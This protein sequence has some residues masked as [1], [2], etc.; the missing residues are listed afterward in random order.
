V[1]TENIHA[2]CREDV[3]SCPDPMTCEAFDSVEAARA[4]HAVELREQAAALEA[5]R[6]TELADLADML[7][8]PKPKVDAN[9]AALLREISRFIRRF[10]VFQDDRYAD[11]L[12]LWV[13]HTWAFEA[14][15]STPYIW[16][17]SPEMGSGKTRLLEVLELLVRMPWHVVEPSEPVTFRMI[18]MYMPT[19]LLDEIDVIFSKDRHGD[20]QTGLRG[21]MNAGYRRGA[22]IPRAENFGKDLTNFK[23]YCPK[24]FA[25]IGHAL[26]DTVIDRSIKI[27]LTRKRR[28]ER[29]ERFSQRRVGLEVNAEDGIRHRLAAAAA[30]ADEFLREWREW[31][32]E[33]FLLSSDRHAEVWE[34][35]FAIAEAAGEEW[36]VKARELAHWTSD[37]RAKDPSPGVLLLQ[38]IKEAF[39]DQE[40]IASVVLL[41]TLTFR[42]DAPWGRIWQG[43]PGSQADL[44]GLAARLKEY[45]VVSRT[46]RFENDV[47]LKGY[48]KSD[49]AD[50]WDRYLPS[51]EA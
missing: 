30:A 45:D 11:V 31:V 50:V 19:L 47:K 41:Q 35:L 44:I 39:G 27:P 14:S 34:P 12:A 43:G 24:A 49:F 17:A 21:I 29:V 7:S 42:D 37:Q 18:D 1:L 8:L 32:P 25:G 33:E 36:H 2:G 28:D 38:H 13:I 6:Q 46:L 26:P 10:V 4:Y 23:I 3:L 16:V 15:D 51:S 9:L 20:T 48:K 5:A 22:Y 40:Q